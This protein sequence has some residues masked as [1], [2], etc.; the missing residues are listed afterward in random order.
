[1][2]CFCYLYRKCS[3]RT[4]SKPNYR[5]IGFLIISIGLGVMYSWMMQFGARVFKEC[6]AFI[7]RVGQ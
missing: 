4:I 3:P 7:F 5:L 6:A 2:L 1:M